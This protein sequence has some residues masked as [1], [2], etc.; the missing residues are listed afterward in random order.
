MN[1]DDRLKTVLRLL[2]QTPEW[3]A[4]STT[5]QAF[6]DTAEFKR[7]HAAMTHYYDVKQTDH[8][9]SEAV[10]NAHADALQAEMLLK[11]VAQW[12]PYQKALRELEALPLYKQLSEASHAVVHLEAHAEADAEEAKAAS[13]RTSGS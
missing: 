9:T 11:S 4:Y 5:Q 12:A 10:R 8:V 1:A 7:F 2:N 6:G 3:N 13:R